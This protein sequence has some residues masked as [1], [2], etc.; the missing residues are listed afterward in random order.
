MQGQA[1]PRS[2]G[3]TSHGPTKN[4]PISELQTTTPTL[5]RTHSSIVAVSTTFGNPLHKPNTFNRDTKSSQLQRALAMASAEVTIAK[6]ALSGALFRADP[7]ACTRDD[8][9]SMLALLDTA[10]TECSPSNVQV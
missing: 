7:R 6:A 2:Q 8:I 3:A 4:N 9:E 5:P 1:M 10:I